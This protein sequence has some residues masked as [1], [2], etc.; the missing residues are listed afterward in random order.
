MV[1]KLTLATIV[2]AVML[3]HAALARQDVRF[4]TQTFVEKVQTDINGRARRILASA[5]RVAPGDRLVFVVNWRNEG[6][7]PV[8]GLALTNAVPRGTSLLLSDLD[9]QV[10]VDGGQ[11][12][13]RL[14]QLSLPT[15]L[16]GSRRAVPADVTHVR[17]TVPARISP[18]ESGRLSYRATVR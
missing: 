7:E 12:W 4:Q 10:S 8:E 15:P 9:A 5:N 2:A 13:G 3:P 18:G 16:G 1:R 6:R 14:E 17:L 11:S